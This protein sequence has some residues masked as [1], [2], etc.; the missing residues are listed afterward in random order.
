MNRPE[1]TTS[2]MACF[3]SGVTVARERGINGRRRRPRDAGRGTW[4]AG[5]RLLVFR[6][7]F[8]VFRHARKRDGVDPGGSAPAH[9]QSRTARR[10]GKRN[11]PAALGRLVDRGDQLQRLAALATVDRGGRSGSDR[12]DSLVQVLM[13]AEAVHIGRIGPVTL[14]NAFVFG[15]RVREAPDLH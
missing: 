4:N 13:M 1:S 9:A 7:R 6:F 12:L 8:F 15:K 10:E 11:R 14:E 3:I 5:S 2:S